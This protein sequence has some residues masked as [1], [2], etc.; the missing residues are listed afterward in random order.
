VGP[1]GLITVRCWSW[2]I[3]TRYDAGSDGEKQ[4]DLDGAKSPPKNVLAMP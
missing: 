1:Y 4:G 3:H 2:R